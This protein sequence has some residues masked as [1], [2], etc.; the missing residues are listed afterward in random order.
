M[1]NLTL[2]EIKKSKNFKEFCELRNY[3]V[4]K[5][6]SNLGS[7]FAVELLDEEDEEYENADANY[8]YQIF[9]PFGLD[10]KAE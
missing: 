4:N 3:D 6:L 2:E 10:I 9:N 8:P 7:S 1:R 5:I